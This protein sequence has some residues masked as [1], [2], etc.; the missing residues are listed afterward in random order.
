MKKILVI[1]LCA[2]TSLSLVFAF[3]A[4]KKNDEPPADEP[5]VSSDVSGETDITLT[6]DFTTQDVPNL[7]E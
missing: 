1:L 6:V 2:I 3:S 7:E 4:C 5:N